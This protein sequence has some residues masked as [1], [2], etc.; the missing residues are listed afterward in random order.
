MLTRLYNPPK[1]TSPVTTYP[2]HVPVKSITRPNP[3]SLKAY[4]VTP[5]PLALIAACLTLEWP[6]GAGKH[7]ATCPVTALQRR[8]APPCEWP[9]LPCNAPRPT[10]S[11][12]SCPLSYTRQKIT[13]PL[14]FLSSPGDFAGIRADSPCKRRRAPPRAPRGVAL[15]RWTAGIS[16]LRSAVAPRI[17][18]HQRPRGPGAPPHVPTDP[19]WVRNSAKRLRVRKIF[20]RQII[21]YGDF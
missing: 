3:I 1:R 20:F 16:G 14:C 8:A 21:L 4:P 2:V 12:C 19:T 9:N 5:C 11:H 10:I 17:P 13:A 7:P 6:L 15:P 18:T